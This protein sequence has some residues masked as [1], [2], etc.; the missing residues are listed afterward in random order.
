MEHTCFLHGFLSQLFVDADLR[1]GEP[2]PF[3]DRVS[4]SL[5]RLIGDTEHPCYLPGDMPSR[6]REQASFCPG[7]N[8]PMSSEAAEG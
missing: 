1:T 5:D 8:N 6:M 2:E 3:S 4:V 7:L